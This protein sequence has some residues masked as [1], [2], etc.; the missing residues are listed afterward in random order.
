M[1]Q[2]PCSCDNVAHPARWLCVSIVFVVF[3]K[4]DMI[5]AFGYPF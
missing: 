3:G 2:V 1:I 4:G 5:R